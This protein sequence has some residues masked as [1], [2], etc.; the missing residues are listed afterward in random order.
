MLST[1]SCD[2]REQA[3]QVEN[4]FSIGFV[5]LS[6]VNAI[7]CESTLLEDV[8]LTGP[9]GH[10]RPFSAKL[11][12]EALSRHLKGQKMHLWRKRDADI[13]SFDLFESALVVSEA[14]IHDLS[15]GVFCPKKNVQKF[16]FP[17]N[18][19]KR[20]F[21]ILDQKFERK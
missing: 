9:K 7:W 12:Q 17:K 13:I 3:T 1:P 4:V 8:A 6:D 14:C 11:G 10:F 5:N 19:L 16:M 18:A 2:Q 15:R 20:R 21:D